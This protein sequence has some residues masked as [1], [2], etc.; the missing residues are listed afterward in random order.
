MIVLAARKPGAPASCTIEGRGRILACLNSRLRRFLESQ[1]CFSGLMYHS[2]RLLVSTAGLV[3]FGDGP[4]Y[5][6]SRDLWEEESSS[7][8]EGGYHI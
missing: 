4:P 1:A 8:L 6:R 5:V 7:P 3:H 2:L